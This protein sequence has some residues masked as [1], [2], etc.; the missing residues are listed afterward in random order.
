MVMDPEKPQKN[1]WRMTRKQRRVSIRYAR[2]GTFCAIG[3][4]SCVG[5]KVLT[6]AS[7]KLGA[8]EFYIGLLSFVLVSTWFCRVFTM[9]AL[10][11]YGKR[12][13]LIFWKSIS[14]V[15]VLPFIALPF[16]VG[17][18]SAQWCLGLILIATFTRTATY[19]MGNTGWYP[20]LHDI[21]PR[22]ITGRFFAILRITWQSAGLILLL[23]IALFLGRQAQWWKFGVVFATAFVLYAVRAMTVIGM[24]ENPNPVHSQKDF[25]ILDRFREVLAQKELRQLVLYMCTYFIAA[26]VALPFQIKFLKDLGY[27]DGVILAATAMVHLGAIISLRFWGRIADRFGNT[28]I[29]RISH[30]AMPVVAVLWI[31]VGKGPASMLLVFGLFILWSVFDAGNGIAQIR[32]MLHAVPHDKQNQLNV[33]HV[34]SVFVM[35][36]APLFAG[37]LLGLS[38]DFTLTTP[39][40]VFNNYHVFFIITAVLF[41]FPHLLCKGLRSGNEAPAT[42]VIAV[43]TQPILHLFGISARTANKN[44]AQKDSK[45]S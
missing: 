42:H 14:A 17:R 4:L 11:K 16:V 6:L 38:S 19:A 28:V 3:G 43:V 34:I 20:L 15:C 5:E 8:S 40:K 41:V 36:I 35:G 23:A 32:Y 44:N 25:S 37:L 26:T 29:F 33:I 1:T 31:F 24:T 45:N 2:I 12:R 22:R 10:E 21:V 27:S 39:L 30:I 9:S 13:V 18:W 7:L